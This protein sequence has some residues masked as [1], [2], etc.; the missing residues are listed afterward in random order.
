MTTTDILKL[1]ALDEEDLAIVSAHVQDA[2]LKIGD[3]AYRPA[4]RRFA[5]AMN[6]FIWEKADGGRRTYERRRTVLSFDRVTAVKTQNI[7]RDRPDAVLELL[8]I[9]FAPAEAPAGTVT[10]IF[11][12]GG[13]I[14]LEVECIETRLADLGTA[15]ATRTKPAHDLSGETKT[16]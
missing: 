11:A 12:G 16:A 5:L 15:W 7:R 6:R 13:A 8:A 2:V 4:E 14:R 9:E 1:I 3:I 10:L